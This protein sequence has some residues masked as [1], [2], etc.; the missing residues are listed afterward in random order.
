VIAPKERDQREALERS[1][2]VAIRKVGGGT[3]A[4]EWKDGHHTSFEPVYLRERCPCARCVD[5]TTGRRVFGSGQAAAGLEF[6]SA[7]VV[8]QY[9]VQIEFS[10]GHGTGLY[11]FDSLRRLCPCPACKGGD[12]P[13]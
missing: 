5:E 11:A 2:P 13:A 7:Q 3:L 9:A 12:L 1:T 8:G 4:I 6:R 10:D